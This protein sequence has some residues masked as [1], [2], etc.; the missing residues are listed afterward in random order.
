MVTPRERDDTC[1][2]PRVYFRVLPDEVRLAVGS[3]LGRQLRG[4]PLGFAMT[5][6]D[7]EVSTETPHS[8]PLLAGAYFVTVKCS[9]FVRSPLAL[10][11]A[12]A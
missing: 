7:I 12:S 11:S 9:G 5:L 1:D 6:E 10:S 2:V 4:V 8:T 3:A